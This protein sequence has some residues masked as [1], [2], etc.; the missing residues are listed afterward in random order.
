MNSV[1]LYYDMNKKQITVNYVWAFYWL[2][3]MYLQT[4]VISYKKKAL[5]IL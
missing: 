1:I 5:K 2:N 4:L 3:R